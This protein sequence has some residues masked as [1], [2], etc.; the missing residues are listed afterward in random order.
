MPVKP[1]NTASIIDRSLSLFKPYTLKHLVENIQPHRFNDSLC[2]KAAV[3]AI[4]D[5][6]GKQILVIQKPCYNDGYPW[7]GQLAF[8]GGHV[9][10]GDAGFLDAALREVQEEVGILPEQLNTIGTLGRFPT[11]HNVSIEAFVGFAAEGVQPRPQAGEVDRIIWVNLAELMCAHLHNDY[12]DRQ[13]SVEDLLY[14]VDNQTIWGATARIIQFL[15]NAA[16]S[17][18]N[19]CT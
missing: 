8:P 13:V 6:S 4:L 7:A 9:E 11:V 19:L 12:F 10:A 18:Q 1:E 14:P 16:I 2:R 3:Y 15:L 17:D 5:Y